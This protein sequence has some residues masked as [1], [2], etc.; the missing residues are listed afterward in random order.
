VKSSC[1]AANGLHQFVAMKPPAQ[2]GK[3]V[4]VVVVDGK[5]LGGCEE[6]NQFLVGSSCRWQSSL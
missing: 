1:H 5:P 6:I 4:P 3:P 2:G